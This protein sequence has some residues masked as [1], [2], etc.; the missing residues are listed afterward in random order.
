MIIDGIKHWML[1]KLGINM[2]IITTKNLK[3]RTQNIRTILNPNIILKIHNYMY[4]C[5]IN[6]VTVLTD[7][8]LTKTGYHYRKG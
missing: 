3:H 8:Q 6:L 5:I 2:Q 1:V 7:R 4:D